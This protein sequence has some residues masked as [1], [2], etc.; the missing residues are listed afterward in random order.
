MASIVPDESDRGTAHYQLAELNSNDERQKCL[1]PF[2]RTTKPG[3]GSD[4]TSLLYYVP[5]TWWLNVWVY[6]ELS[7]FSFLIWPS[8][9][10][11]SYRT[12]SLQLKACSK[13]KIGL[14]GLG[15]HLRFLVHELK[16]VV[17][18]EKGPNLQLQSAKT[19]KVVNFFSTRVDIELR[20]GRVQ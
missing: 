8:R 14:V 13:S 3:I 19:S 18:S 16:L 11:H 9:F 6:D 2:T 5:W 20:N 10:I 7:T 15:D 4:L 1:D 12:K 17:A